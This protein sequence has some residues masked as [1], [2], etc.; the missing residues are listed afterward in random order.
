MDK[1]LKIGGLIAICLFILMCIVDLM[2]YMDFYFNENLM[3]NDKCLEYIDKR[4]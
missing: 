4:Q 1:R 3:D 2:P